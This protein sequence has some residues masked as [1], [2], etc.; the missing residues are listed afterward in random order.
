MLDGEVVMMVMAG[1]LQRGS[2]PML[3]A[4]DGDCVMATVLVTLV[5]VPGQTC[6]CSSRECAPC[7]STSVGAP[8]LGHQIV[9]S[10][11]HRPPM[12]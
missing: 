8:A 6:R 5:A 10:A 12:Q 4:D 7:R 3:L 1:D 9:D 2:D 11:G